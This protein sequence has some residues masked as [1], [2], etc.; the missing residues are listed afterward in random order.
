[1]EALS[2]V[3]AARD[4]QSLGQRLRE[5]HEEGG[6]SYQSM[7]DA[8]RVNR[9]YI[10]SLANRGAAPLGE[11]GLARL[12]RW[13]EAWGGP[14]QP[15]ALPQPPAPP[16]RTAPELIRTRDLLGALGFADFCVRHH[17]IGVLI[18]MPGTGK[19]TVAGILKD[20]L[21]HAI[22]MEA[23]LSMRLTDLLDEIAHGL[24]LELSGSANARTQKIIRE[25][26]R[27][28]D[29]VLL[30]DEA[31]YLKKWSVEKLDVLR[32]IHD[33]SG[34]TLLLFGTPAFAH[35]LNRCDATQLSRRMFQYTFT[36]AQKAEIR[37][38][39]QGYDMDPQV[40]EKLAALAADTAHGG[41]GTYTKLLELCLYAAQG[42]RVTLD[43][44]Q[45]AAMYKPGI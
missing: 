25:L 35:I 44:F 36:G 43:A 19:T 4:M 11:E 5:I 42:A 30:V 28:S 37:A 32:K 38:A 2:T 27:R 26:R 40:V 45:E 3:P 29:T 20:K 24:G 1:M 7:A 16:P 9:S 41:M 14:P 33:A 18:G 31:E 15:P 23:W 22:R 13:A 17:E 8:T 21:P 10:S 6:V 39:L 12:W 34:V